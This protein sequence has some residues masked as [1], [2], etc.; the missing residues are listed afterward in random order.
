MNYP[1]KE[2][3]MFDKAHFWRKYLHLVTKKF[4]GKKILEVGSGIGGILLA[5]D[6]NNNTIG[7]IICRGESS[8]EGKENNIYIFQPL[9]NNDESVPLFY[10]NYID[11]KN[12]IN[13][14]INTKY[15]NIFIKKDVAFIN[16]SALLNEYGNLHCCTLNSI[17]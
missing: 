6:E 7:Y 17:W 15:D 2:L 1:G 5:F 13:I 12:K 8:L 14:D 10:R 11:S 16:S 9:F 4:I 3:E